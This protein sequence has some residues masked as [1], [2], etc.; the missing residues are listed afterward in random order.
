MITGT[1]FGGTQDDT[2]FSARDLRSSSEATNLA[3][4]PSM[5]EPS[6][7]GNRPFA[8]NHPSQAVHSLGSEEMEIPESPSTVRVSPAASVERRHN[9]R[10]S[11]EGPTATAAVTQVIPPHTEVEDQ[12]E[13]QEQ[14]QEEPDSSGGDPPPSR[15]PD[16][17]IPSSLIRVLES[18]TILESQS[19][20]AVQECRPRAQTA[21]RAASPARDFAR[22][23]GGICVNIGDIT[24]LH[25]EDHRETASGPEYLFMGK[26]WLGADA[27]VPFD[28]LRA[29]RREITRG[30]RLAVVVLV[31][32]SA[33][34]RG[35]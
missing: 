9:N 28:L 4:P 18:G 35:Q 27:G 19:A 20:E 16:T 32:M 29:Y 33:S 7:F 5:L 23:E 22:P 26:M 3:I 8:A 13:G 11:S 30:D 15:Q 2:V 31:T 1:D 10:N 34:F 6:L 21:S 12:P 24:F 14:G 17:P 25:V